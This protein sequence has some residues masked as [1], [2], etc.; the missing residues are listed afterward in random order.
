M[1]KYYDFIVCGYFLYF[2]SHCVVEVMYVHA[3]DCRLTEVGSA[4]FF[5]KGKGDTIIKEINTYALSVSL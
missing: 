5:V 3:S 2:I 1:P 4:K